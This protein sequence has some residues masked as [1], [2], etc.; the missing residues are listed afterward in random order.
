MYVHSVSGMDSHSTQVG[1]PYGGCAILWKRELGVTVTPVPSNS[2]RLCCSIVQCENFSFLLACVYMPCD[3]NA[4]LQSAND[5]SNILCD[6]MVLSQIH[7]MDHIVIAGDLNTDLSRSGSHHTQIIHEFMDK[8]CLKVC[9]AGNIDYT[10]ESKI[11]GAR[12]LLDHIIVSENMYDLVSNVCVKHDGDNLSDHSP[13]IA[14]IC[15]QSAYVPSPP[16]QGSYPR[17]KWKDVQASDKYQDKLNILL[18][19]VS[20]PY[21]ALSCRNFHC[22]EHNYEIQLF[23]DNIVNCCLQASEH[24][25]ITANSHENSHKNKVI[26]GWNKYVA[27]YYEKALFWH[28]IWKDN[29]S[30]RSGMLAD[31]RNRTRLKYHYAIRFVE[32]NKNT[33]SANN[34]A[35]SLMNNNYREFWGEVSN[36]RKT[37]S[38]YP[39]TIDNT[40]GPESI[41]ELF[42]SKSDQL[43]NCVS[44]D[45][46]QMAELYRDICSDIGNHESSC[47]QLDYISID[48]IC[49]GVLFLK[50]DKSDGLSGFTSDHIIN[51]NYLLFD[52]ITKLMS[53]MLKHGFAP[54]GLC[55]ANI[56]PI[57]KNRKKSL[58]NSDNYRGIAL[59]SIIGK[60]FDLIILSSNESNLQT[61]D[62]QFGFKANHSTVQCTLAVNETINYYINNDTDVHCMLL[63]ASKAFDRVEYV[64]LFN[65]LRKRNMC[66]LM[67][68]LL[69]YMYTNQSVFISWCNFSSY[70]FATSNG[71]KQGGVLSPILFT[72]YVDELIKKLHDSGIGCYIGH[73]FMGVF[74]YADDIILLAPTSTALKR[75]LKICDDF[76]EEYKVKFNP[77]KCKYMVFNSDVNVTDGVNFISFNDTNIKSSETEVHLGNK[78]GLSA[79]TMNVNRC[80]NE[81]YYHTN[82][83]RSTFSACSSDVLYKLFQTYCM[84]LYGLQLWDLTDKIVNNFYTCW[85]KCIRSLLNLPYRTHNSLLH[86]IVNDLDAEHQIHKRY[87]KFLH[88][89]SHSENSCMK[90]CFNLIKFGSQSPVSNSFSYLCNV[91]GIDKD[92]FSYEHKNSATSRCRLVNISD[93]ISADGTF[94]RELLY[95]R[96][97]GCESRNDVQDIIDYLCIK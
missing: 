86:V 47:N 18:S 92:Y 90:L 37:K 49:K 83:L 25:N 1:R 80:I 97:F 60:L 48:N 57:P 15:C 68:R 70:S 3:T 11:N 30:P 34:M 51:G 35:E 29:G 27:P 69:L 81:M 89:L 38:T 24:I 72:V 20:L 59:S 43:Y 88:D 54:E 45:S 79:S 32:K 62:L 64:K 10:F 28:S 61:S 56:M 19:D 33:V 75:L 78:I 4:S 74:V 77:D 65:L 87:V 13:V 22:S 52:Y 2:K 8:N 23:H 9:T 63:D 58:Y 71:V 93:C 6:I 39:N 82:Y 55:V 31:I 17:F 7:C 36:R 50:P 66:P 95:M 44:Y 12:S 42:A 91:Y 76:S 16:K 84:P 94:I 5:F 26:P 67:L 96:D 85:R 46:D 40:S 14:E 53:C 41:A 21:E 73:W